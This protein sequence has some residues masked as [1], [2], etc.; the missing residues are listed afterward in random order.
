MT[1]EIVYVIGHKSPD[2]DSVVSAIVF[3]SYLKNKKINA[4]AAIA[5]KL[6]RESK[7]ILSFLK[8]KKPILLSSGKN[9]KF[10]LVDHGNIEEAIDGLDASLI[11]GVVDH[12]KMSGISTNMPIFYRSE[13]IGSTSTLIYK[14]FQENKFKLNKKEASLLL[15][16]VISDTLNL[17]SSTTTQD[18]KLAIKELSKISRINSN[19]LAKDLFKAKSDIT[20]I[21]EKDIIFSDYKEFKFLKAKIGVGVHETTY[22]EG[23]KQKKLKIFQEIEKTKKE[24]GIDH[25]FFGVVD[26]LNKNCFFYL[27]SLSEENIINKVFNGK[28]IED[29]IIKIPGIVSRKKEI[30]P[31]LSKFFN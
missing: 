16:G 12:H 10:F 24:K 2:T 8:E 6:N 1:K 7:F 29:G 23:I 19:D 3:A 20:G 5:G 26:I 28:K 9:K 31:F 14:I 4:R 30:M 21:K 18:D 27:P 17:R 13:P 15:C 25:I 22:P 11:N